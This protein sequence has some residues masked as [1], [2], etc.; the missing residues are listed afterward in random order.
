MATF[1][2]DPREAVF[3]TSAARAAAKQS[4]FSLSI[5]A[6]PPPHFIVVG[7]QTF[8]GGRN[9]NYHKLTPAEWREREGG[10]R[11][12]EGGKGERERERERREREE[13]ERGERERNSPLTKFVASAADNVD[14]VI[15]YCK[16]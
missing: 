1:Q 15:E 8:G 11:E 4:L 3:S 13:R 14:V 5:W 2:L 6:P 16:V 10:K 7:V 12:R 9:K